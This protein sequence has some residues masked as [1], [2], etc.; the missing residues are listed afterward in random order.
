MQQL[1]P[2]LDSWMTPR[3][4]VETAEKRSEHE[5]R[6]QRLKVAVVHEWFAQ[7]AGSERV[8]EQL[9]RIFPQADLFAVVDFMDEKE[10]AFLR[11]RPVTT[12]FIQR[13]P[14]ARRG[15]RKYLPLMPVA[16][17]QFDVSGYDLVISSNHAVAKGVITGPDQLHVSYV[18][19]PIRYAWDLQHQYLK[20][21]GLTHG[22]KSR[23]ARLVL[24]YLRLWDTRTAHGVDTFIANSNYVAK[25]IRK[26]YG[27]P[28]TVI[29]PPVDIDR[30]ALQEKKEGFYLT[31]SRMVPYKRMPM[32]VEAFAT[33]PDRK[34]V[35][36]GDGPEMGRVRKSAEGTRNIQILGYQP[37][38]VM[39]DLMG[40]ARAFV[41]AAA[42]DFGIAPVEAQACGTP[43]VAYGAG[44]ALETVVASSD[45]NKRT[46]MLFG[47]QTAESVR[48]AIE[49][50]EAAGEFL[51]IV[52][53]VN[54]ER[55]ASEHFRRKVAETISHIVAS[56]CPMVNRG[57]SLQAC[58]PAYRSIGEAW[59]GAARKSW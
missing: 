39:S 35:V 42:E 57:R 31:A 37:H 50:F 6:L 1:S 49:Q 47:Q 24:H 21:S 13:L 41:F 2:V 54:A 14:L 29:Y 23:L 44:G 12:S 56:S 18:H 8:V 48:H 15:F 5:V 19:T 40:R 51:P 53:R 38:D 58:D 33:M 10:R 27:R 22:M 45:P 34:L 20:E 17:E 11:G 59:S 26:T 3:K 43:V 46:G 52:C 16:V 32:I 36:I 7:Y 9:L 25:R 30:F 4:T 28:A 55:F